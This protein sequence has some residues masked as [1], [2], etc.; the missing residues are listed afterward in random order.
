[1]P[2]A[3]PEE[4]AA[5]GR[6]LRADVPRSA[7][8]ELPPPAGRASTRSRSWPRRRGRAPPTSC[9]CATDG[10]SPRRWPSCV[11]RPRSWPPTWPQPR[12][13]ACACSS[14]A[15]PTWRTSGVVAAPGGRLVLDVDELDEPSPGRGSGT[16]S[17]WR[18]S[19]VVAAR[20]A[21]WDAAAGRDLAAAA[22]GAYRGALRDL[23]ASGELEAWDARLPVDGLQDRLERDLER[24]GAGWRRREADPARA[25]EGV[26]VLRALCDVVD[27]LP[28]LRPSA[29]FVAPLDGLDVLEASLAGYAAALPPDHRELLGR[30][31]LVQV[32][33]DGGRRGPRRHAV[34]RG[35]ARRARRGRSALP[36]RARG[37]RVGARALGGRRP[38]WRPG[39]TGRRG[40]APRAGRR[41]PA[42]RARADA[43][44]RRRPARPGRRAPARLARGVRARGAP[45]RHAA[46]LRGRVRLDP[47]PGARPSPA[48]A[49]RWPPTSARATPSTGPW[50]ASPRP[51]RTGPRPTGRRWT[52][53]CATTGCPR[54]SGPSGAA[55]G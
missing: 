12:P 5:R 25:H 37:A 26:E 22:A 7:H 18:A 54:P 24:K 50:P 28:R 13:P 55:A 39:R 10:C 8:A 33:A 9:P 35:P 3:T 16:S 14:A 1:M 23:A 21:G 52:R 51:T 30:F 40:P 43:R 41:R 17:G 20:G 32:G 44:P 19:L 4:R 6:A 31:R 47:G 45:P 38:G 36:G 27:G 42:P 53:P 48:T 11:E 34:L 29:P 2:S 46:A 15:T 49:S